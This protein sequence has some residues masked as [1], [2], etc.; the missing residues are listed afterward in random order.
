MY[1]F[2]SIYF[3]LFSGSPGMF[4]KTVTL[5]SW[6]IILIQIIFQIVLLVM[7]PYG[8]VLE[9]ICELPIPYDFIL[10]YYLLV[11]MLLTY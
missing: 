1:L 7:Q 9:P 4:L 2:M 10:Q 8:K 5:I 3:I 11:I 6:I